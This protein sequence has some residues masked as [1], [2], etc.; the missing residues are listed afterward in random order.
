MFSGG[1]FVVGVS[2]T[3][4]VSMDKVNAIFPLVLL[5]IIFLTCLYLFQQIMLT[6]HP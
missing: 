4:E 5:L 1:T 6:G 2:P 3:L